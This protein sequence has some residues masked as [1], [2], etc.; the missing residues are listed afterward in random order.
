M[1]EM[2]ITLRQST[3]QEG[4]T[5]QV[6]TTFSAIAAVIKPGMSMRDIVQKANVSPSAVR[7]YLK[8]KKVA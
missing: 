2:G 5:M 7:A 4:E 3:T 8:Q 6:Q 1:I